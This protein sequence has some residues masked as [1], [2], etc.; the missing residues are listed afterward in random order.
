MFN[1]NSL[2]ILKS[3][4]LFYEYSELVILVKCVTPFYLFELEIC[5]NMITFVYYS[6]L[7]K[8]KMN[9]FRVLFRANEA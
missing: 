7:M 6:E 4:L 3:S 9:K 8:S 2:V 1:I 5:I